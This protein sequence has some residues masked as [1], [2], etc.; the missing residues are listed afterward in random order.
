M[1]VNA[2]TRKNKGLLNCIKTSARIIN[3]FDSSKENLT[4]AI[5]DTGATNSVI[6]KS[7]AKKLGLKPVSMATVKGVHGSRDVNVYFVKIVLNNENITL[8]TLVTECDELSNSEDTGMLIGMDLIQ[9]GDFCI[10]NFE[11][12]TIMT[13]RVPSIEIMDFVEDIRLNKQYLKIHK[14][15]ISKGLPDKCPCGSGRLFKNCHGK[16]PYFSD[17]GKE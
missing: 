4:L 5:W 6:T 1:T 14:I 15:N 8:T 12:N 11:G 17:N 13:F 10:S 3:P 7:V 9:K 2:L 16:S